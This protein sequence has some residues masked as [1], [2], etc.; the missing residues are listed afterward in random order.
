MWDFK[1]SLLRKNVLAGMKQ[2]L[3]RPRPATLLSAEEQKKIRKSLRDYTRQFDEAD[4]RAS[5]RVSR[6]VEMRRQ[7][8]SEEWH[9]WRAE[10]LAQYEAG[11]EE[12]AAL[13]HRGDDEAEEDVL[14]ASDSSQLEQE[15]IEELVEEII[16]E[17][18]EL[19]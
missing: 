18:E 3:W 10:V 8:L 17:I 11:R 4:A 7:R 5:S 13:L 14:D 1:G 12:R 6:E 19:V 2:F 15:E 9:S 16:E